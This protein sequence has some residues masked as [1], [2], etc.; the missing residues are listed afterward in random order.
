M[1][2]RDS[3]TITETN[4]APGSVSDS[5]E[6]FP[7]LFANTP[8]LSAN[9]LKFTAYLI[10]TFDILLFGQTVIAVLVLIVFRLYVGRSDTVTVYK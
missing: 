1:H 3:R 5:D 9:T 7:S 6:S 4:R 10:S 8:S 2:D